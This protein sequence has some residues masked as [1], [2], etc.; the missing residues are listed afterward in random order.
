MTLRLNLIC[1]CFVGYFSIFKTESIG[2]YKTDFVVLREYDY[3]LF[4]NQSLACDN[5]VIFY[6]KMLL[7]HFLVL[8]SMEQRVNVD[9]TN[10]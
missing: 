4:L 6:V 3:Y 8:I 7:I 9:A 5:I 2:N 1:Q 10:Q